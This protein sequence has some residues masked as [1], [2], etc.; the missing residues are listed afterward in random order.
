MAN[1]DETTLVT[2]YLLHAISKRDSKWSG[3]KD[4]LVVLT[5][6]A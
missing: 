3:R 5:T 1:H 6:F 4:A 2:I